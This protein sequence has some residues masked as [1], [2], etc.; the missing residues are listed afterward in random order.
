M[1]VM[2]SAFVAALVIA[3]AAP[4]VLDQFGWSSAQQYSAE[5]VSLD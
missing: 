4:V 3:F 2:I 5:S 1:K